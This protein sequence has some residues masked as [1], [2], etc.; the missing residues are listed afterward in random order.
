MM[1]AMCGK[2]DPFI[3]NVQEH[4]VMFGHT[5]HAEMHLLDKEQFGQVLY[6]NSGCNNSIWT[7]NDH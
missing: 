2:Y 3:R 1:G 6:V 7:P 4:I 5:H